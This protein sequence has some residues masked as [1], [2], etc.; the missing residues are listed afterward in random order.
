[1]NSAERTEAAIRASSLA[2]R[3]PAPKPKPVEDAIVMGLAGVALMAIVA[4]I[5][6]WV[7]VQ[8]VNDAKLAEEQS[9]FCRVTQAQ[10]AMCD[11]YN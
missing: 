5:L 3:K 11:Y 6:G 4:L 1:M 7:V 8:F 2:E 10:S 9:E